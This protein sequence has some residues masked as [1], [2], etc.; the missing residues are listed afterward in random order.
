MNIA[1]LSKHFKFEICNI[2]QKIISELEK[3]E[4]NIFMHS[5]ADEYFSGPRV[6]CFDN[7]DDIIKKSDVIFVVGGDGTIIH[8]AKEAAKFD[9]AIFG[10]NGG[11]LGFLSVCDKD[12]LSK[13]NQIIAG[14]YLISE[15]LM[16]EIEFENKHFTVLNDVVINRNADASVLKYSV[17][18]GGKLICNYSAD[19]I[20]FATPTGS[21]AYSLSAG[22]S[23]MDESLKCAILTPIC[24]HTLASRSM[25][26]DMNSEL[27]LS[28]Q[29]SGNKNDEFFI[30]I[31]GETYRQS[32]NENKSIKI[33]KSK[34]R[35]KFIEPP[36]YNFYDKI[37]KK[38]IGDTTINI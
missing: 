17:S 3:Y 1:L 37:R 19:G 8:Y 33:T 5:S 36:N 11:N 16:L 22:G 6:V 26:L 21:T 18:K 15:R 12:E 28:I 35:A 4:C 13:V 7:T 2:M 9:K 23:I 34:L 10:I 24:A 30:S 38:L 20:I 29:K 14:D 25:I 27:Q 31:D 32:L